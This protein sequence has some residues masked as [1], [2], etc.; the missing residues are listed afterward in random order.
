MNG[1]TGP[2]AENG[3]GPETTATLAQG[4]CSKKQHLAARPSRRVPGPIL[5][6]RRPGF[7]ERRARY[8]IWGGITTWH[9]VGGESHLKMFCQSRST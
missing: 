8:R 4:A 2:G 1:A 5:W 3:H 7:R 6:L 9:W